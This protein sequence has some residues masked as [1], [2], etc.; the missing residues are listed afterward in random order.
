MQRGSA[1]ILGLLFIACTVSWHSHLASGQAAGG[2]VTLF[3]G[4]NLD[5]WH[6]IGDANW[7]LADGG[8]VADKGTFHRISW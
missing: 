6:H 5:H 1:V 7:R 2:W 8:G 4:K 3:D